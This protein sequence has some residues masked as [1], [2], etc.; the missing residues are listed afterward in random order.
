[1]RCLL[2]SLLTASGLAPT[3][4]AAQ[5][6]AA[7]TPVELSETTPFGMGARALGMGRAYRAV[8]E[9]ISGIAYNPAT[10]AQ[11]RQI[12]LSSGIAYDSVDRTFSRSG[13][14][15]TG[16]TATRLDHFGFA[17]PYPTYRGSMVLGVAFHRVADLDQDLFMTGFAE[18]PT[19]PASGIP[20]EA[21]GVV[22]VEDVR[23]DGHVDAWTAAA[24]IDL[25]PHLSVGASVSYLTGSRSERLV[26]AHGIPDPGAGGCPDQ[27]PDEN[28]LYYGCG[29]PSEADLFK[30]TIRREADLTGY[31]G[32]LGFLAYFDSG[33]RLG[34]TVDLPK[35]LDYEGH[36]TGT[37]EDYF[38]TTDSD[39]PFTNSITLP[40]SLS[41]GISFGRNG[42]L[43]AAD[44][45]WT[46][47]TQ[48]DFGGDIRGPDRDF[49]YRATTSIS[50]G[51]EYRLPSTPLRL[52]GGFFTEPLPY[53]LIAGPTRLV[54]DSGPD[55]IPGTD[56]DGDSSFERAYPRATIVNDRAFWTVGGGVLIQ[57][58][59]TLDVAWITGDWE[60]R[61]RVP[62]RDVGFLPSGA[63]T[64]EAVSHN[65][66]FASATLHFE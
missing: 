40:A 37:M 42:L 10:L 1:L 5:A 58:G 61:T 50:V 45:S 4:A 34:G 7:D 36:Q 53:E 48:I 31:T 14:N 35:Q 66:V 22:E 38:F 28:G 59:L 56:D 12:E 52:R 41:G 65:R 18:N 30:D 23:Q 6:T 51:A 17:Y 26:T 27:R 60:R 29:D 39:S 62:G 13:A 49:A 44:V 46:D 16:N 15:T 54:Y 2:L 57:S 8:G 11:I 3:R 55:G 19:N 25:S 33:F 43:L 21:F 9:D 20:R 32:S 63:R 64:R 24:A 47:W